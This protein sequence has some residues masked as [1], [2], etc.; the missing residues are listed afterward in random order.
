MRRAP[1]LARAGA[2]ELEVDDRLAGS[3][4]ERG[5]GIGQVGAFHQRL[6]LDQDR[7]LLV[8]LFLEQH[9]VVRGRTA[10]QSILGTHRGVDQAEF[11][12]GG[13]AQKLQES[14]RIAEARHLDQDS[15]G[16]LALNGRLDE[17]ELVDALFDDGDRLV[18][19]LPRA[20]DHGGV[21]RGNADE[22]TSGVD[23][24]QGTHAIALEHTA[25][26]LRQ[27][28]QLGERRRE[29]RAF[30]Q[31]HLDAVAA[32]RRSVGPGYASLAER[33][34]HFVTQGV[35]ALLADVVLVDFQQDVGAAL[36]I[37][38]EDEATLRPR[39]PA[40]DGLLGKEIRY[41]KAANHQGSEQ[42]CRGL[43]AREIQHCRSPGPQSGR[44]D[45]QPANSNSSLLLSRPRLFR[46]SPARSWPVCQPPCCASAAP[47]RRQRSRSPP[48]RHP[49]PW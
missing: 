16:A 48:G 14:P 33:P 32:H 2:V 27:V 1:K 15:V 34:Q 36:K 28:A 5:L 8:A 44:S 43:R 11:E 21:R 9:F 26:R 35:E 40:L 39:G 25:E 29:V 38:A 22:P 46:P 31:P 19:R 45:D 7:N 20:L 4:I 18:D 42:D 12:L 17:A 23:D 3:L 13:A 49:R 6:P 24:L 37:K 10:L 30:A 41:R 47:A